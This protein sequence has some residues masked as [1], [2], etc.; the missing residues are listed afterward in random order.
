MKRHL[1]YLLL[2]LGAA[3]LLRESNQ[4]YLFPAA[5]I[6]LTLIDPRAW[7][8][9]RRWKL[10]LFFFFVVAIPVLFVG[11]RDALWLT[12]PYNSRMLTLNVVMVER[13]IV[14]MLAVKMFTNHLSPEMLSR[15]LAR[16]RLQ[17]FDEVLGLAR[18]MLPGLQETVGAELQEVEWRKA[19]RRPS[20]LIAQLGGLVSRI[21]FAARHGAGRNAAEES[22]KSRGEPAIKTAI[23]LVA[24]RPNSGK[25]AYLTAVVR[26]ARARGWPAGGLL[27]HGLWQEGMKTGYTL[28]EVSTGERRQLAD[29][30]PLD[31]EDLVLDRF[32]FSSAALVWGNA[33]LVKSAGIVVVDEFGALESE[34]GGLW[35]GIDYLLRHHPGP[36]LIAV[37]PSLLR[38]LL[39]RISHVRG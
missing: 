19:L 1:L 12:I 9:F 30:K 14:I 2:G 22:D 16:L 26:Q 11:S 8:I 23:A 39:E 18:T 24:G 38:G 4:L 13:S 28:E 35:P 5:L 17:Q 20:G 37:R 27:S 7:L 33:V 15:G 3:L 34:G 25:T 31:E 29:G 32:H 10:W 21:L 36:L 6:L